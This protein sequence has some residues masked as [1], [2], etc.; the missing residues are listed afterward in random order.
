M[1]KRCVIVTGLSGAGKNTALEALEELDYFAINNLMPS[2]W[3]ALV[4][5]CSRG[6]IER[7]AMVIDTRSQR[8]MHE[9]DPAVAELRQRGIEP[10]WLF[11]EASDQ[12][13]IRRYGL[14]RRR[15]PLGE[16]STLEDIARER[17]LLA[18]LRARANVVIDTSDLSEREL[19][20]RLKSIYGPKDLAFTLEFLSFGYKFGVPLDADVV[21]DLRFLPNPYYQ[22]EFQALPGTDPQVVAYVLERSG[23]YYREVAQFLWST[24]ALVVQE[25]RPGFLV[26]LGCTGGRHRSVVFAQELAKEFGPAYRTAVRHRDLE[27]GG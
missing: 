3:P 20:A 12:A 8:F 27:R 7:L 16:R 21:V 11:L 26:A 15:H 25:G 24:L 10:E 9:L 1:V 17:Q 19:A 14:T 18:D 22:P 6:G 4:E 2:L 13:V 5:R 23:S